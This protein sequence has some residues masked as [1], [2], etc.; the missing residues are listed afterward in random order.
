MDIN[1]TQYQIEEIVSIEM[2][3]GQLLEQVIRQNNNTWPMT[4]EM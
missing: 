3:C 1:C 2:S 4:E